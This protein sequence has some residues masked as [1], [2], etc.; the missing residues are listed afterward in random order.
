MDTSRCIPWVKSQKPRPHNSNTDDVLPVHSS[1][2]RSLYRK[3]LLSW[4]LRFDNF[5]DPEMLQNSL[6][7]LLKTGNW[8]KLGGRLRQTLVLHIPK[9]FT[10]ERPAVRFSH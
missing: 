1:D 6:S 9:E 8:R 10:P 3:V 5:L 2:D 4:T 7:L